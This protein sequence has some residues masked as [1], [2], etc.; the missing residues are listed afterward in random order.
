MQNHRTPN[1]LALTLIMGAIIATGGC[2]SSPDEN[3]A[4]PPVVTYEA[5]GAIGDGVADDLPAICAAHAFAN[6]HNLPVR[7]DPGA[8]YNLGQQALTA[9]IQT[10]TDWGTSRFIID[11]SQGV[12]N[13]K[14]PLFE[15]RS[16]MDPVQLSIDSLR[17]GQERLDLTPEQDTLVLVENEN[18]KRYIRRGRNPTPGTAQREV[19]I[20]R[21]DGAIEGAITWDYDVITNVEAFPMDPDPLVLSGGEFTRIAN[22]ED[23]RENSVYWWRNITIRRSNVVIDGITHRVTGEGD[24]GNAYHGFLSARQCANVTYRNCKVDGH[25]TYIIIGRAG[26]PVPKG[27]YGYRADLVVNFTMQNCSMVQTDI[28]D[29]SRWGV[30]SSNFMKNILIEDCVLSR[31]D[32]HM[33]VSGHFTIRRSTL[34]HQGIKAIGS[35]QLT[36]EAST[37]NGYSLVSFRPDYGSTWDGTVLVRNSRWVPRDNGSDNPAMF[38]MENDGRHDFGYNCSM[39]HVIEIDGLFVDDSKKPP[40]YAGI[41]FFNDPLG[42]DPEERP[43]PYQLTERVDV[44]GL[45]IA[46]GIPP[47]VSPNPELVKAITVVELA[48]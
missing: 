2:Q 28:N 14:L 37:V 45:T 35:G 9:V 4:T 13:Y 21:K 41:T 46:S 3:A 30:M 8:V 15:I 34:G 44:R 22:Q 33:G 16:K 11:D 7:S 32:V 5:F 26:L 43:F 29:D 36:V 12:E 1:Q 10:N 20:L 19:F 6:E 24:V 47:R 23:H 42:Q 39:P 18:Q 31:V 25:K 38:H 17:K 40:S 27:T 48:D